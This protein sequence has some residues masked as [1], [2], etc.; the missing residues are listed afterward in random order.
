VVT[1]EIDRRQCL[2]G[3]HVASAGQHDIGLAAVV[4]ARPFPDADSGIAVL[5][6]GINVEPLRRGLFAGD[7]HIDAVPT[8][9]TMIGHPEQRVGVGWHIDPD[10][11]GLFV[12]DI[13]DKTRS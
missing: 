1:Q 10:N 11:V 3:R 7:D 8:T 9:Q 12:A 2:Q 13:V 5:D 6:R 4:V